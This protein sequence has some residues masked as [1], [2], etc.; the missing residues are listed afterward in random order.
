MPASPPAVGADVAAKALKDR[1]DAIRSA[2]RQKYAKIAA[3][4]RAERDLAVAVADVTYLKLVK[5]E[6]M[7]AAED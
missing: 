6:M 1:N 4:A 7:S 3:A 5:P 2:A